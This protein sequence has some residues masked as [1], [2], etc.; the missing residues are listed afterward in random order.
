MLGIMLSELAQVD[1]WL[2]QYVSDQYKEQPLAQD[3]A[4]ISKVGEEM[5]EAI[6]AF[7]LATGQNPRKDNTGDMVPV[8]DELADTAI[9][10]ILAMLHF[11][12]DESVVGRLLLDKVGKITRRM[13]DDRVKRHREAVR[14]TPDAVRAQRAFMDSHSI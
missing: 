10:A 4:R 13:G 1:E 3:W 5:G 14:N 2:D 11:T 9:T 12:K 8:M 7:I 6:S